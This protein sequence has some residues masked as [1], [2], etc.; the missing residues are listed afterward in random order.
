MH[1][2]DKVA[3]VT[4]AASGIGKEIAR[5]FAEAGAKVAIAD[6]NAAAAHAAAD[7]LNSPGQR[8]IA[9][10]MDVTRESDVDFGMAAVVSAFG[11]IDV[12]VSNAGIQIVAPLDEFPFAEWKRMLAIHLDAFLTTRAALRQMYKQRGGT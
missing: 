3:V 6:L 2:K 1:L 7:E 4:G 9:V 10:A 12:L 8:A 5:T 11:R